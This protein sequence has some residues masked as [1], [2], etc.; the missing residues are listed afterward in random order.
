MVETLG[1]VQAEPDPEAGLDVVVDDRQAVAINSERLAALLSDALA[2]QRVG[3]PAEV[4][5]S[6]VGVDEMTALNV[7]HMDGT[8]PTDVLAF[9]IDGAAA[10]P[11][12][13]PAMIGD[14]VICPEIAQRAPQELCD[15]LALLVVHGA[16]HLIGHD[17]AE[18]GETAEMKRLETELLARYHQ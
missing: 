2:D 8:G 4:G 18:P 15:E 16:L 13:Q 9:P 10:A 6:F 5:L 1:E 7:E 11:T 14:I 12:G 17:H 3:A